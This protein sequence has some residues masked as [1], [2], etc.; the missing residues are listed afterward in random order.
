MWEWSE[1]RVPGS[2]RCAWEREECLGVGGVTGSR[3]CAWKEPCLSRH[4]SGTD[5][6]FS[7]QMTVLGG[8]SI[9]QEP[10][11]SLRPLSVM[12]CVTEVFVRVQRMQQKGAL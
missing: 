10:G 2:R 12:K 9:G 4:N 1:Q 8:L 11:V 3:R 7:E 5:F 6:P